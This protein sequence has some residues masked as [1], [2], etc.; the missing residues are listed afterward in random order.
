[1]RK[2]IFLFVA[3]VC[4]FIVTATAYSHEYKW[5]KFD[6]PM[7][8]TV[9]VLFNG[10]S[11]V[12]VMLSSDYIEGHKKLKLHM[13]IESNFFFMIDGYRERSF[14]G[15][16]PRVSINGALLF[17]NYKIPVD[18]LPGRQ[19]VTL[20]INSKYL[21]PDWNSLEFTAGKRGDVTYGGCRN[22]CTSY[23]IHKMWF[24]EK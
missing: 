17:G 6:E 20:E 15:Y 7:E 22:N 8:T 13:D 1:M 23:F 16:T 11:K 9:K 14:E 21:K 18:D 5:N 4:I 2:G 24:D 19:T 3:V 10:G 12:D